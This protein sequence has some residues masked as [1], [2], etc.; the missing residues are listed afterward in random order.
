[1][2]KVEF[3]VGGIALALSATALAH[4]Q[5]V[6]RGSLDLG[7]SY[8]AE[9]SL[10]ANTAQNFFTQGGSIELGANVSHGFGI[11]ANITGTHTSSVGGSGLPLSLVTATFGPRYRFHA[12]RRLSIYGEA[13]VG[14]ANGF[15]SIF[16]ASGS[17][18][19]SANGLALQLGGG[20]DYM[21]GH[22]YAVRL[23]DAAYVRTQL[24]NASDNV[25]NNLQLGAGFVLR[26]H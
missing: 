17:S 19:S 14:E 18:Q 23:I 5:A 1:M 9:R 20:I 16:P 22:R 3:L 25:Q 21:L 7:I 11:T 13:L 6:T 15:K 12:D 24:P 8:T 10:K 26:F 2:A 4:A